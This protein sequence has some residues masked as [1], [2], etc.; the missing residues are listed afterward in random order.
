LALADELTVGDSVAF[1]SDA[2]IYYVERHQRFHPVVAPVI[3]R[4]ARGEL[5]AHVSAVTLIEV[6]VRPLREGQSELAERYRQILTSPSYFTLHSVTQP[7]AERAAAVRAEYRIATAD[8]IVAATALEAECD[9]LI[10][11]NREHFRNLVGTRVL[12]IDDFVT[13]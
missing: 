2:L 5:R 8:A 6:L 3:E 10:T 11:N 9:F 7:L 12:V 13:T 1:D 4:V